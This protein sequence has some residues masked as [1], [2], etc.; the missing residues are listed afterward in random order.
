MTTIISPTGMGIRNDA[1]G[2]GYFGAKR[3][4]GLHKGLDFEG[5]VGQRIA[6]PISGLVSRMSRPYK[7]SPKYAG[8]LLCGESMWIKLWYFTPLKSV[9]GKDVLQGEDIGVMQDIR[10]RYPREKDMLPHVHLQVE[11]VDPLL[12]LEV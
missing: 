8:I 9:I 12:L 7:D 3:R 4:R 6:A 11:L 10:K 2:S 1:S 5:K